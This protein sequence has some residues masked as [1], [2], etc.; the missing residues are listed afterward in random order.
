MEELLWLQ[1][2]EIPVFLLLPSSLLLASLL[3]ELSLK[4]A[5]PEKPLQPQASDLQEESRKGGGLKGEEG[6]NRSEGN[7]PEQ[8]HLLIFCLAAGLLTYLS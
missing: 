3:A 6:Q 5:E 4:L 8:A 2:E 1:W 7:R